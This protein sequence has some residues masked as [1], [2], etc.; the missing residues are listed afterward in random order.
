MVS[1]AAG[2]AAHDA[3]AAALLLLTLA[4]RFEYWDELVAAAV[5][6]GLLNGR[7]PAGEQGGLGDLAAVWRR[8]IGVT[9]AV[10][11]RRS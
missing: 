10:R 1:P 9:E 11:S 7:Q 3:H 8:G 2:T 6:A 4:D 5:P